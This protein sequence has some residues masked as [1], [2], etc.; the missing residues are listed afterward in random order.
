M[1]HDHGDKGDDGLG[2]DVDGLVELFRNA[3]SHGD[4]H[5]ASRVV[6]EALASEATAVQLQTTVAVSQVGTEHA[7]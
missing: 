6:A 1:L 3:S 7:K 5:G 2:V 4:G